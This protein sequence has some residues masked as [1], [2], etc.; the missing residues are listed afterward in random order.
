[1]K[2]DNSTG[3]NNP[4]LEN[5]NSTNISSNPVTSSSSSVQRSN[6]PYGSDCNRKN[7][8]HFQ[9]E[10]HPGDLDYREEPQQ[11]SNFFFLHKTKG[12]RKFLKSPSIQAKKNRK[13]NFLK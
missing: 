3:H 5:T 8:M 2:N 9:S 10:A 7:P 1:M 6:C 12:A 4:D 13:I 11:N